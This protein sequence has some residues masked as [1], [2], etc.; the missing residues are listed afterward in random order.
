METLSLDN[1]IDEETEEG[2]ELAEIISEVLSEKDDIFEAIKN[3]FINIINSKGISLKPLEELVNENIDEEKVRKSKVKFGLVTVNVTDMKAEEL[4]I[5]EIPR[6]E[7]NKYIIASCYLPVFKLEPLDGKYYLDG[8]FYNKIPFNMVEELGLKPIIVRTNPPGIRNLNFPKDAIV[9]EPSKTYTTAMEFDPV[10]ADELIRIG[11]FDT[12]KKLKALRGRKYYIED[13][14]EDKAFE[15][16]QRVFFEEL[17]NLDENGVF[18]L[19]SK[20]RRLFEEIIP[21]LAAELNLKGNFTY[22]DL[23][24]E[25]LERE[26]E[27]R[28]IEYL[29]IY[30]LEELLKELKETG[31]ITLKEYRE[32]KLSELVKRIIN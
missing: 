30:K 1:F 7:L 4:F 28:N 29:K 17:D 11:Y 26:A 9:I 18:K 2:K 22:A 16:I 24:T 14:S 5:S 19:R 21:K 32:N 25:L 6:G 10:K 13:F 3:A 12:Y 23:V 15:I 27:K 20:Y 31:G 8:G